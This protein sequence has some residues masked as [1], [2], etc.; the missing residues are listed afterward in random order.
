ISKAIARA[1]GQ[2]VATAH[3]SDH[4]LGAAVYAL[5][6]VNYAGKSVDAERKWQNEQLPS[7]IRELVLTTRSRKEKVFKGLRI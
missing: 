5:L 4:S 3:M 1:A 7:E 6:A 2:V